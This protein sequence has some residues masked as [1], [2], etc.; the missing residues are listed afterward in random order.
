MVSF[1]HIVRDMDCKIFACMFQGGSHTRLSFLPWRFD[2]I[3]SWLRFD[4][5]TAAAVQEEKQETKV[6]LAARGRFTLEEPPICFDSCKTTYE[7]A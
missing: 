5:S 2:R 1:Q 6:A 7:D 3:S 4:E